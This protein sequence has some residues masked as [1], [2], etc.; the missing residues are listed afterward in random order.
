M[1]IVVM[2]PSSLRSHLQIRYHSSTNS[3]GQ[4]QDALQDNK[5]PFPA[6]SFR[7]GN[8]WQLGDVPCLAIRLEDV[9][10]IQGVLD[11]VK[12]TLLR[13]ETDAKLGAR[14]AEHQKG[15]YPEEYARELP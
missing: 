6:H 12:G 3:I 9:L 2:I 11:I 1:Y 8:G 7:T 10:S 4:R 13:P 5:Q 15:Y 14:P